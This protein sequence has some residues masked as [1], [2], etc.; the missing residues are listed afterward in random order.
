M[1]GLTIWKGD[2]QQAYALFEAISHNCQCNQTPPGTATPGCPAHRAL[3][4]QRFIDGLL[5]GQW[6][7]E[8]LLS[9]EHG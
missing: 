1:P 2:M 8:R 7:R 9:E 6:M 4:E 3:G 5:W